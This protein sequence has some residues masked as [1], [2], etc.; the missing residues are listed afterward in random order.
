M[1]Y[2]L[3]AHCTE[4]GYINNNSKHTLNTTCQALCQALDQAPRFHLHSNSW[5]P[6]YVKYTKL[7]AYA[8]NRTIINSALNIP[9]HQTWHYSPLSCLP[10]AMRYVA[11]NG[12][13]ILHH[14]GTSSFLVYH[15]FISIVSLFSHPPLHSLPFSLILCAFPINTTRFYLATFLGT[16]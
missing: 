13:S 12:T 1:W 3:D 9:G 2:Y 10:A 6:H 15:S 11:T 7:A 5:C 14:G 16:A 8:H 4:L